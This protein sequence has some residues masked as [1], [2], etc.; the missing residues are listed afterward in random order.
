[1]ME[2]SFNNIVKYLDSTKIFDGISFQIYDRE[3]VG[4]V[5]V[6]GS[7]KSTI[8]KLIAGIYEMTRDDKGSI[9]LP[10]GATIA[11]LEQIPS[12]D[13]GVTV[14]AV[15]SEAFAELHIME[16]RLKELEK[17][18]AQLS[19]DDLQRALNEYSSIHLEYETKGGY[20]KEEKLSKVCQGLNLSEDFRKKNFHILSGGE[21]T[22]VILGK[23]L[24]QNPDILLLD[25][26]T[27]HLDMESVE[28]LEEYLKSYKGI[29]IVVSHDRYFLDKVATKIIEVEDMYCETYK[30]N[31]SSY[32]KQK[33]ENMLIQFEN[34]KE[35]QKR[36]TAMEKA[37]KDLRD[38]AIRADNNKFFKRAAS[39]QKSL[40][41]MDKISK[42]K[43]ERSNMKLTFKETTRSGNDV[44]VV[45]DLCK[46]YEDK[47]LFHKGNMMINY[48]DRAALIGSNGSG[49][50][51]F[52][53]MLLG[54]EAMD[55]GL[56]RIGE[57]VKAAYLPQNIEFKN[58]EATVLET[59]RED[60]SILEGKA[61][62]Y[63]SKFMFYGADV[64]KKIKHL[65][66]GERVR[67]KLSILLF[68]DINLLIMDEPTNH[69]DIDSIENLEESLKGFEGTI[70]YISHDRY[71]INNISDRV[72]SIE[73]RGFKSYEGNYDAY[74]EEK[75]KRAPSIAKVEKE[76][77][78]KP[79]GIKVIDERKKL[80]KDIEKLELK[81]EEIESSISEID[82]LMAEAITDYERLNELHLNKEAL[83]TE[84]EEV[85]ELWEEKN[86][87]LEQKD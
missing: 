12:Y 24:L 23:I 70:F 61:R 86:C 79:K 83:E 35:Q 67:L 27:N 73:D 21:K 47:I 18:M 77:A 69:L 20:D 29:V 37:I 5:G 46:A 75:S 59:F 57:S 25:E 34:Y 63:L 16:K 51:T 11:Y 30:G 76:K 56:A 62:E 32:I 85:I 33:E 49:K 26:P 53:K 43:F 14:E 45:K 8:L 65:S 15:L 50:T 13:E 71:F 10:R 19:D 54:Q 78:E 87:Q 44:I 3:R 22:T 84:L 48:G 39:M 82:S 9:F 80:Q 60:F 64:F 6:N 40:E 55:S 17:N 66:G 81:I 72:I 1:M 52:L 4:I 28:W 7:G 68:Q 42:P 31:Y 74:K 2:L 38:W 36:I 58:E 41:K